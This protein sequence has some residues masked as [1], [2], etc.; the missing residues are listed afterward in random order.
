MG[1]DGADWN[2]EGETG[3]TEEEKARGGLREMK[4]EAAAAA[5]GFVMVGGARLKFEHELDGGAAPRG[6][7]FLG[8][9]K[10]TLL[11]KRER[12]EQGMRRER[13]LDR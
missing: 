6:A 4:E 8:T 3:A 1:W 9:D 10:S 12:T 13:R 7:H 5:L 11:S 2:Q